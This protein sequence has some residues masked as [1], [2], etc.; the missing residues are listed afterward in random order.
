MPA[1]ARI[2]SGTPSKSRRRPSWDQGRGFRGTPR[3]A[4]PG[5]PGWARRRTRRGHR[6][7]VYVGHDASSG[8]CAPLRPSEPIQTV[9]DLH[10]DPGWPWHD[11][12]REIHYISRR[13][14]ARKSRAFEEHSTF[15]GA[16]S[17]TIGV[18]HS[19]CLRI[20]TNQDIHPTPRSNSPP[21][22][23]PVNTTC[24]FFMPFF[25]TSA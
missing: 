11:R 25:F 19:S 9:S 18:T 1:T 15:E 12:R 20:Q 4:P 8:T 24:A 22:V 5:A 10:R 14:I 13:T 2:V 23:T 6:D 16:H 3:F 21:G 17:G 7:Q